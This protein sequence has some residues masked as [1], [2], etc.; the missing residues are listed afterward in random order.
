MP[1]INRRTRAPRRRRC[2]GPALAGIPP[3]VGRRRD[4][5]GR[6][7]QRLSQNGSPPCS[8][9]T[10]STRTTG[11][12][13]GRAGHG[14]EQEPRAAGSRSKT[15]LNVVSG[16]FNKHATG[17]GI[18]PGQTGNILSGA[19]LQKGAVLQGGHQ[20]GPGTRRPAGRRD[21]R[22][23]ASSWAANSR[24]RAITRPNFSMAYSSHISW[25]RR[26]LAGADGGL[27]VARLRQPLRQPGEPAHPE[28]PRPRQG[29]RRRPEPPGEP[30]RPGEARRVPHQRPRGGNPGR[31]H[32][33][34]EGQRPTTGP[35]T[36]GV[37]PRRCPAP[38]TA[39][40]RTS[41]ST[42]G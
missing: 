31:A 30:R 6:R 11:G 13:R 21:P 10:G 8:W 7:R 9:A 22:S 33:R 1:K 32:P 42:C 4:R 15:K 37:P 24:S 25:Q 3:G 35:A 27:S 12:R 23:P 41:A 16:L 40:P 5:D 17:V 20:H 14:A 26:G 29:A 2:D 19:A 39:C 28:H 36:A 18:H 34:D 38:T